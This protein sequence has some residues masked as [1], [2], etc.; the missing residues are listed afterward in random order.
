MGRIGTFR[1]APKNAMAYHIGREY[2]RYEY[3]CPASKSFKGFWTLRFLLPP[4]LEAMRSAC[5]GGATHIKANLVAPPS[6]ETGE[7]SM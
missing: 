1:E 4:S 6:P 5:V 3:Y 2:M 7:P